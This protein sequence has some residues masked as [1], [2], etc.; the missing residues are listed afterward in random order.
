MVTTNDVK[1]AKDTLAEF[2]IF[3]NNYFNEHISDDKHNY[4]L[5]DIHNNTISNSIDIVFIDK[6]NADEN[7]FNVVS[8]QYS[9]NE[10]KS[11]VDNLRRYEEIK[12][13]VDG[14]VN[15]YFTNSM[16]YDT[17]GYAGWGFDETENDFVLITVYD[18]S[19]DEIKSVQVN[20]Q[21]LNH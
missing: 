15:N 8:L 7:V 20:L 13:E 1:F 11:L 12:S 17:L 18:W 5:V 9:S 14:L 21:D 16:M 19:S 4:A 6:D 2:L 3:G 10:V